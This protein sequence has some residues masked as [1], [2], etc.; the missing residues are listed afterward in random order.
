MN[1]NNITEVTGMDFTV[2]EDWTKPV[3]K[4]DNGSRITMK[5]WHISHFR[6][7]KIYE[8]RLSPLFSL[9]DKSLN[10]IGKYKHNGAPALAVKKFDT[11]TSV[12]CGTP[13]I[14]ADIIRKL[15][16][17][18]EVHIYL[19]APAASLHANNLFISVHNKNKP[20]KGIVKL[21]EKADVYDAFSGKLI[22][23][24]CNEFPLKMKASE[25]KLF[26]LIKK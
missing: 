24:N 5:D 4:L 11:W 26:K 17:K 16:S 1:T 22:C 25:T 21:R 2:S 13:Y 6:N 8:K 12:Y 15:A 10:I 19:D 18:C 7:R 23:R 3:I 14:S 20:V 9:K